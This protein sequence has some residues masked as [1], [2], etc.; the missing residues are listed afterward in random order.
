MEPPLTSPGPGLVKGGSMVNVSL[1]QGYG[2]GAPGLGHR[3]PQSRKPF[4]FLTARMEAA[5]L[6]YSLHLA[7]AENFSY[8]AIGA[9]VKIKGHLCMKRDVDVHYWTLTQ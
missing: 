1:K 8:G 6:T 9:Y 3:G 2:G 5:N 4:S 7:N